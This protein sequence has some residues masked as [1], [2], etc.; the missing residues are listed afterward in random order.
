MTAKSSRK[1]GFPQTIL[2]VPLRYGRIHTLGF[3]FV[4]SGLAKKETVDTLFRYDTD[5]C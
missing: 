5:L 3:E 4:L 1:H 2:I